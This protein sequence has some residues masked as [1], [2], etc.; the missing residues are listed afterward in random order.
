MT[1]APNKFSVDRSSFRSWPKSYFRPDKAP[2]LAEYV[3][4]REYERVVRVRKQLEDLFSKQLLEHI[5]EA[6]LIVGMRQKLDG[7]H[8]TAVVDTAG[9]VECLKKSS[10]ESNIKRACF[11]FH[12]ACDN[13]YQAVF[14]KSMFEYHEQCFMDQLKVKYCEYEP[15]E[16]AGCV[17]KLGSRMMNKMRVALKNALAGNVSFVTNL[18]GARKGES[19][20][21]NIGGKNFIYYISLKGKDMTKVHFR[22]CRVKL[23]S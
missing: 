8:Q 10:D 14:R 21:R 4:E 13:A 11:I 20:E 3:D 17:E 19:L 16:K 23:H 22:E 1:M 7:G 15:K 2:V 12:F 18:R 6:A 5:Q 9:I